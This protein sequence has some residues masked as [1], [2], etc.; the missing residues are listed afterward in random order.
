MEKT[1]LRC[2][3][4]GGGRW[5][6][7]GWVHLDR[8][9]KDASLRSPRTQSKVT[10]TCKKPRLAILL[11][12]EHQPVRD[13]LEVGGLQDREERQCLSQARQWKHK[14]KAVSHRVRHVRQVLVVFHPEAAGNGKRAFMHLGPPDVGRDAGRGRGGDGSGEGRDEG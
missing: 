4:G 2:C 6:R 11:G 7:G 9:G 12:W 1:E 10:S 8:E 3:E 5:S 13:G 14:A